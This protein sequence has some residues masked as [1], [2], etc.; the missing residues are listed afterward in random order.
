MALCKLKIEACVKEFHLWMMSNMLK[1]N[2]DKTEVLVILSSYRPRPALD[3]LAIV[4]QNVIVAQL[5]PV[6]LELYLVTL[7]LYGPYRM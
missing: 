4:S 5:L 2:S 6:I 1:M 7:S 3:T